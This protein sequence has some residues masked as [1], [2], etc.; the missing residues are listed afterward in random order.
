MFS[1]EIPTKVAI[2]LLFFALDTKKK[3]VKFLRINQD[4]TDCTGDSVTW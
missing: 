3:V 1:F 4:Q 2:S